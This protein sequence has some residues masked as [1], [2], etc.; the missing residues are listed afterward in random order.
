M[1]AVVYEGPDSLSV[2]ERPL[3]SPEH[4]E[5]LVEVGYFGICGTDLLLWK[6]GL[7][8]VEP[9]VILGHEF[10]GT[11]AEDD[12]VNEVSAGQNVA[13]EPLLNCGSCRACRT[14]NYHV[15]RNLRVIGVDADGG[16]APY[17]AVPAA[18]LHP[19]PP[20]LSLR[21]AVLAEPLSVAVHMVKRAGVQVGDEVLILG[22]GP[23]GALVAL[24]ARISGAGSVVV[25]EPQPF[26]REVLGKLG[27]ETLDP[28]SVGLTEFVED[29][30]GG[31]GV[32]VVFELSGADPAIAAA[33][34]LAGVR[35]TVLLGA[36]IGRSP[37]V[38]LGTVTLRE[39]TLLGARVYQS[40][41]VEDA[42]RILDEGR[43]PAETIIS[44]ETSLERSLAEGF[45]V[46]RNG[47]DAMKIVVSVR[48]Q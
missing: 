24:V 35:G 31:E 6:G 16:A 20:S 10:C 8:R 34:L 4:D 29:R 42:I 25:S 13:I 11:V 41:D 32:D 44:H 38:P 26:R 3:P 39:Q 43:I 48:D 40:R 12:P 19:L 5:V 22:G 1:Q 28:G 18:C 15:C 30:T 14:G 36:I 45:E 21:T 37:E 7:P 47:A 2:S 9:P 17:V 46:L 23:I 33:P 27:I